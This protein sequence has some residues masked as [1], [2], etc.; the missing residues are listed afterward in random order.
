MPSHIAVI[1]NASAGADDKHGLAKTLTETFR[2]AGI[3]GRVVLVRSGA[4]VGE[5]ALRAVQERPQAIVAGGGDGTINAVAATL[6]GAAI[7]L[8]ILPPGT[9][10]HFA[11]DLH[12]PLDLAAAAR[13]VIAGYV[14]K[15]D[16]GD[17][18]DHIFLGL[19]GIEWVI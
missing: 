5:A 13:N 18:N 16:I 17:V 11:K 3:D 9:L 8:G 14:D 7:P 15:V 10:N 6:I 12:I 1:V 19:L 4:E 2:S